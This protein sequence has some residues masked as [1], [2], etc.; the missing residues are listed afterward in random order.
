MPLPPGMAPTG[1][2]LRKFQQGVQEYRGSH[3]G[4]E[5]RVFKRVPRRKPYGEECRAQLWSPINCTDSTWGINGLGMT[6]PASAESRCAQ[7][8]LVFAFDAGLGIF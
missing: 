1:A 5:P 6:L 4:E 7:L 3:S 2:A 8:S